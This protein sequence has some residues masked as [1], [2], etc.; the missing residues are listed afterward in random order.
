MKLFQDYL[1]YFLFYYIYR[2]IS[3]EYTT[4]NARTFFAGKHLSYYY[5][6]YTLKSQCFML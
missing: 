1:S 2:A 4:K 5:S 3:L 6:T